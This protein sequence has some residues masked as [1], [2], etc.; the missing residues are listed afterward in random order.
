MQH[1]TRRLADPR[2]RAKARP[3]KFQQTPPGSD[4]ILP[5]LF[6]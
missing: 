5:D 1:K 2:R 3:T 6:L 4:H